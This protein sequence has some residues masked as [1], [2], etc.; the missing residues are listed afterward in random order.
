MGRPF[1]IT[2]STDTKLNHAFGKDYVT[3]PSTDPNI[4]SNIM[5][6][7]SININ[8]RNLGDVW[9][10]MPN[11][12]ITSGQISFMINEINIQKSGVDA[13]NYYFGVGNQPGVPV[14]KRDEK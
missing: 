4:Y 9:K 1:E 11:Q 13:L 7:G 8:G 2:Q 5:N 14:E 3:T 10:T 12:K 6:Y